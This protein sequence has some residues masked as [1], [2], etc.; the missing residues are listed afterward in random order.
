MRGKCLLEILNRLPQHEGGA[1]HHLVQG[2]ADFVFDLD[3]LRLEIEKRYVHV[4]VPSL[5][6]DS[7]GGSTLRSAGRIAGHDG[8]RRHIPGNHGSST[9]DGTFSDGYS[10]QDSGVGPDRGPATDIRRHHLPVLLRLRSA[11]LGGGAG[12]EVVD[13]HYPMP[14][15]ALV[16][17][18]DAFAD[19]CMAGNLAGSSHRGAL[20][21]FNKCPDPGVVTH[22]TAVEIHEGM[23]LDVLAQF[24]VGGDTNRRTVWDLRGH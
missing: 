12:V 17:N 23:D 10:S 16:L 7:L 9:N 5:R 20:L 21:D 14:D 8:P 18:V 19:E 3:V 15:K 6:A 1:L 13:E 22:T 2:G 11:V 24:D 4:F